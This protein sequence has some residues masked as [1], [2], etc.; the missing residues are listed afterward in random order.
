MFSARDFLLC[1]AIISLSV[2]ICGC[3]K[4]QTNN[5]GNNEEG[6]ATT[7]TT[8]SSMIT[9]RTPDNI[10]ITGTWMAVGGEGRKPAALLVHMLGRDRSTYRDFQ[11]ILADQGIN[12][13]AIDMRGHGESTMGGTLDYNDF[14][15]EEWQAAE[16]DLIGGL[17]WLRSQPDVDPSKIGIVG[18]SIGANLTVIAAADEITG[19][20]ENP[21]KFV[22]LLS[23]GLRYHFP[24]DPGVARGLRSIPVYI[25]S[26]MEDEQSFRGAQSLA[27]A[28]GGELREFEGSDHGTQLFEAHPEFMNE[29][30]LWIKNRV[31]AQP[32][33]DDSPEEI[34][35]PASTGGDE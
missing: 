34:S 27:N 6:S 17:D 14:S 12:S 16:N 4:Q 30:A 7:G 8:I 3:P 35:E 2:F 22:V 29:L 18:A 21:P 9:Y 28:S 24:L 26:A 31:S 20:V 25:A 23:P 19:D 15:A 1:L 11:L 5:N 13:L 33:S 10:E 32:S